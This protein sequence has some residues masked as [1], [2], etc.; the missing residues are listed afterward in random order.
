MA[1][2][3]VWLEHDGHLAPGPEVD[4]EM[5]DLRPRDSAT[6]IKCARPLLWK[7][8]AY[9]LVLLGSG[10][11][12]LAVWGATI[13]ARQAVN[14]EQHRALD[15]VLLELRGD[16]KELLRRTSGGKSLTMTANEGGG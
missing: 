3:K 13:V 8:L 2:D 12:A 10:I 5:F 16:V 7:L 1:P 14:D 9:V 4:T 6:H 15:P 11:L